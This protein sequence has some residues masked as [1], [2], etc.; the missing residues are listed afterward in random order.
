MNEIY[1]SDAYG[2]KWMFYISNSGSLCYTRG[3]RNNEI[4]FKNALNHYDIALDEYGH[5]HIL[6][7]DTNGTLIY[8]KYDYNEWKKYEIL[9]NKSSTPKIS[10]IKLF[11]AGK[12]PIAFYVLEHDGK[13][14]LAEQKIREEISTAPMIIDTLGNAPVFSVLLDN[15]K[16]F[17]LLY[18]NEL[19]KATYKIA[20]YGAKNFTAEDFPCEHDIV[21]ADLAE[22]IDGT[23]HL[24]YIANIN[25][26]HTVCYC[27]TNHRTIKSLAF[28]V[29]P[30]VTPAVS[31][32]EGKIYV[33]WLD[34]HRL[35][36][37]VSTNNGETFSKPASVSRNA[38]AFRVFEG[39]S[40]KI[41]I[42]DTPVNAQTN[43]L[44]RAFQNGLSKPN[45]N[46]E[47]KEKLRKTEAEL[48]NIKEMYENLNKKLTHL[49]AT[50][51]AKPTI[52]PQPH[53]TEKYKFSDIK[54]QL[55]GADGDMT[56]AFNKLSFDDINFDNAF[57]TQRNLPPIVG[58]N[59]DLPAG[60]S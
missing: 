60:D 58:A 55:E 2:T 7:E 36:E 42:S 59:L 44:P 30:R 16:C 47:I 10:H 51:D 39:N 17:H 1:L 38:K 3:E 5:F 21:K 31:S 4:L 35:I 32:S 11:M 34:T 20:P 22:G 13:K 41:C 56:E 15:Q 33:R 19:G 26:Y 8:I 54:A 27:N 25:S 57:E 43:K 23:V 48:K 45:E 12:I 24:T 9:K 28:G 46:A 29:N 49:T 6:L 18:K 37:C 53:K 50:L 14:L 52:S 40:S